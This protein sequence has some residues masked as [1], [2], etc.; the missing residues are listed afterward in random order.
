MLIKFDSKVG[1]LTM[2][3]EVAVALLK[4]MGHSGT[5]PSA[6]L[7]QDLPAAL[8]CLTHALEHGATLPPSE[9]DEEDRREG[10]AP[11]SL[12]QRAFPLIELLQR[13]AKKNA[14]VIWD[15]S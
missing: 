15:R 1:S 9:Q 12:R 7:A 4:L 11:V 6:V 2:F 13:A 5:V 3:G 10:K 8:Q 14:D